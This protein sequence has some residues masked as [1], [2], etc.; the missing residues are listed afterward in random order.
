MKGLVK[1]DHDID[2]V[3]VHGDVLVECVQERLVIVAHVLG[4]GLDTSSVHPTDEHLGGLGEALDALV[5]VL[6]N[7]VELGRD[8]EVLA[9]QGDVDLADWKNLLGLDKAE[10]G[11]HGL[12]RHGSHCVEDALLP[13]LVVAGELRGHSLVGVGDN[14]FNLEEKGL[15]GVVPLHQVLEDRLA[16]G[17]KDVVEF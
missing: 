12:D 16:L 4:R 3:R 9:V 11:S 14:H 10:E 7:V 6:V 13:V 15:D 8:D 2:D 5:E 17:L 1:L